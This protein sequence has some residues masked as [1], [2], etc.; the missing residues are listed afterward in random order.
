M[1]SSDEVDLRAVSNTIWQGKATVFKVAVGFG[2]IA[3]LFSYF[4]PKSIRAEIDVVPFPAAH[5]VDYQNY[6][7]VA[8]EP[9]VLSDFYFEFLQALNENIKVASNANF[10]A[11]KQ[12]ET[13]VLRNYDKYLS[14][15]SIRNISIK[16]VSAEK[17]SLS[18]TLSF[19]AENIK[20]AQRFAS[21]LFKSSNADVQAN[22]KAIML[23]EFEATRV[24]KQLQILNLNKKVERLEKSYLYNVEQR[25]KFL[26]EQVQIAKTLGID[27]ISADNL[28]VYQNISS[29]FDELSSLPYFL[30]GFKAIEKE[31]EII[32]G[33]KN[34]HKYIPDLKNVFDEIETLEDAT[35]ENKQLELLKQTPLW[36]SKFEAVPFD[37]NRLSI[38]SRNPNTLLVIFMAA[39]IGSLLASIGLLLR[40]VL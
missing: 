22:Y 15:N 27:V 25:L 4:A 3:M 28:I 17:S 31:I 33:R 26:E 10:N 7:A 1:K 37:L 20:Q 23:S 14:N 30:R 12:Q 32:R 39:A 38:K 18:S 19:E 9:L 8:E 36:S 11:T 21:E 29:D 16:G 2:V 5:I 34:I 13:P 40:S 35:V 24:K 6:N